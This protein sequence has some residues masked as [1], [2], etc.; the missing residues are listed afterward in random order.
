MMEIQK[1]VHCSPIRNF[2]NPSYNPSYNPLWSRLIK[3]SKIVKPDGEPLRENSVV[4][5]A[6]RKI[7]TIINKVILTILDALLPKEAFELLYKNG[8]ARDRALE[9]LPS[10]NVF[11]SLNQP[12]S[13]PRDASN[14]PIL[15]SLSKR[16]DE[17]VQHPPL[18]DRA[19]FRLRNLFKSNYYPA[20]YPG[21]ESNRSFL[22]LLS[23]LRDKNV[24]RPVHPAKRMISFF[25]RVGLKLRQHVLRVIALIWHSLWPEGL[26]K[27]SY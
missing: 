15:Q 21:D 9:K 1:I 25:K 2:L 20:P 13:F 19:L 5:T 7:R 26:N 18:R 14:N 12:G 24:Q 11:Y 3:S 10:T 22:K 27:A 23:K 17:I 16:S 4:K 6:S 8:D